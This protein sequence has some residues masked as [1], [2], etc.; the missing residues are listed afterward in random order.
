MISPSLALV[1]SPQ[2]EA[3]LFEIWRYG[4]AEFSSKQADM[5]LRK[6][7]A[8]CVQLAEWPN[9]GRARTEIAPELRSVLVSPHV[10]FY[11]VTG[12]AV[13]IVRILHGRRDLDAIFDEHDGG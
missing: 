4:A 3:D 9:S 11:R 5:H 13:Q 7:S 8:A 1:W 6:L 2:A 10:V 12:I